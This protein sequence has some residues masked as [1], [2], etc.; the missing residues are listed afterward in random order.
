[1]G[2]EISLFPSYSTKE[3]RITNYCL[4]ILRLLYEENPKYLDEFFFSLTNGRL[5]S[6]IGVSFWQQ[7]PEGKSVPD[8]SIIQ[9][10]IQI[11]IETKKSGNGFTESQ[12]I[13]HLE[14]LIRTKGN[15]VLLALANFESESDKSFPTIRKLCKEKYQ[16]EI[17]F[18]AVSF[19]DFLDAIPIDNL[20]KNLVDSINELRQFFDQ[21]S[22]LPSWKNFLDIV[23]CAQIP[24]DIEHNVYM[25]PATTGPYTHR[26]CKYFGMYRNKK[27]ERIAEIEAVVDVELGIGEEL[28]WNNSGESR[29]DLIEKAKNKLRELRPE[30]GPTRIFLL[31]TMHE[32]SFIKSTKGGMW[33][34]KHY[35]DISSFQVADAKELAKKLCGKSW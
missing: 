29:G 18:F 17:E 34:S 13:G 20:S 27:V 30:A 28:K 2:K 23:N 12:L 11:K 26:R 21:E 6:K 1:M 15:R 7:R 19:E 9:H 5:E 31:G 25:C 22:L 35:V 24:E 16:N 33:G 32:T 10:P 8:G 14:G 4:L 3:N